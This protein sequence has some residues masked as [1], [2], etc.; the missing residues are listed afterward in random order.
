MQQVCLELLNG[1]QIYNSAS[2][3]SYKGN[4]TRDYLK[5]TFNRVV[6]YNYTQ[7][8]SYYETLISGPREKARKYRTYE[9]LLACFTLDPIQFSLKRT[10]IDARLGR[11][12]LTQREVPPAASM[13]S[14]LGALKKFQEKRKFELLE[15]LPE[16]DKLYIVEPTFLFYVRWRAVKSSG[17]VQLDLFEELVTKLGELK[18]AQIRLP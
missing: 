6:L 5:S 10:E 16:E 13:N 4:F 11:M 1:K 2:A 12:D 7:F 8:K 9:L 15:W 17:P 3:K 18:I 14:T